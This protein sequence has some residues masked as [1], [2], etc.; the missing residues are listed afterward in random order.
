MANRFG[1]TGPQTLWYITRREQPKWAMSNQKESDHGP[2]YHP[3]VGVRRVR[4]AVVNSRTGIA[5][6]DERL[7]TEKGTEEIDWIRC[8]DSWIGEYTLVDGQG[9]PR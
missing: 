3:G 1:P 8:A 9:P 6:E 2:E 4:H 5:S 7:A